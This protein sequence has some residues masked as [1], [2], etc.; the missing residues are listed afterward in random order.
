MTKVWPQMVFQVSAEQAQ[1]LEDALFAVGALSV[2]YQDEHDQPI[3]EP[4]PGEVRLWNAIRLVGL[5]P[6]DTMLD[7]II[8][9]LRAQLGATMPEP[10]RVN[11]PDQAWERVWME[12]FKP[13]QFGPKLWICPT[14]CE[15]VDTSA[16]NLR[17][18]PGLAF[19]TGSHAT[20]AQ[21]LEW[22]GAYDLTDQHVLDY[23]CGSGILAVA[24]AMLGAVDVLAVDIDPQAV[25]ATT[26][27]AALNGVTTQI[28]VGLPALAD[29]W[30][31][32]S[33][34][35][36]ILFQPLMELAPVLA[37]NTKHGGNLVLSGIL[38][39]QVP[40]VML[41]Y[42]PYFRFQESRQRDDWALLHAIR[43]AT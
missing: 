21:C 16:V 32:D 30:L 36:N 3:L 27:N 25:T 41:R 24:A 19:G 31:A 37:K 26:D 28:E 23:G 20:T 40:E 42:T 34:L 9:E 43:H 18:D 8:S 11:L 1:P 38:Q 12:D 14:H 33:V 35:A 10:T 22:L 13:I 29:G 4:A 5:F 6:V 2:M 39:E 7:G 15:P 17:L